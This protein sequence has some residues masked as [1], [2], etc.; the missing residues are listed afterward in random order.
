VQAVRGIFV[1][2]GL[3]TSQARMPTHRPQRCARSKSNR[4]SRFCI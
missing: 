2:A 3:S 1:C 4:L